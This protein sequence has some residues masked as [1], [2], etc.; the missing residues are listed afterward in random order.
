MNNLST[1]CEM[2]RKR[3]EIS[4]LTALSQTAKRCLSPRKKTKQPWILRDTFEKA[5]LG[6]DSKRCGATAPKPFVRYSQPIRSN[7]AN[8]QLEDLPS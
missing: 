5:T 2:S 3:S 8:P 7:K 6:K 1:P 4:S